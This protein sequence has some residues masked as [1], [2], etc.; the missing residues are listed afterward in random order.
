M[1]I[2]LLTIFS[3]E[4]KAK[5]PFECGLDLVTCF[6]EHNVVDMMVCDIQG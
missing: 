5:F 1:L 2:H 3:S 4:G 6:N